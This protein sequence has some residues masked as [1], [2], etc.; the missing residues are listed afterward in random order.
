MSILEE[1]LDTRAGEFGEFLSQEQVN[2][3]PVAFLNGDGHGL[4]V[5][6]EEVRGK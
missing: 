2:T 4:K 1:G 6:Q 3:F 5:E